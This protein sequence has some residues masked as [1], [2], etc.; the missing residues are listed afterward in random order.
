MCHICA[1]FLVFEAVLNLPSYYG[2]RPGKSFFQGAGIHWTPADISGLTCDCLSKSAIMCSLELGRQIMVEKPVC[3]YLS[4][5]SANP[6]VIEIRVFS[7]RDRHI[8]AQTQSN[9]TDF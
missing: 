5:A 6:K 7:A 2:Y 8:K 9:S 4:P 3:R 1:G